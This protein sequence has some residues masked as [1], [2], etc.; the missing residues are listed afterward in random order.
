MAIRPADSRGALG[1]DA[2]APPPKKIIINEKI[3]SKVHFLDNAFGN[4]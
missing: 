1:K 4:N 3:N 2:D